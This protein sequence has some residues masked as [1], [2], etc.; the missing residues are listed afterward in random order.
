MRTKIALAVMLSAMMFLVFVAMP[1]TAPTAQSQGP[2]NKILARQLQIERGEIK[3][4]KHEMRI[5]S[6]TMYAVLEASGELAKRAAEAKAQG[7]DDKRPKNL[8]SSG[9]QGCQN[10]FKGPDGLLNI[11]VNQDCSLRRQAEEVIAINPTNPRNLIAGQNDSRIGFNHCGYDWSFDGGRTWGDQVPPFWQFILADGHTADACSDPT[12]T[13][14]A[15]GNAYVGGILFDINSAA[16]AFVV[17]KSNAGIGGA[18]YHSPDA[19]LSF[20]TYRDTPVG[21][22]ANDNNPN[23]FHDKEYIVADANASS[24]KKNNVY[25]TWTRF[26]ATNSPIYFS[27]STN[28]GATWSPGVEISG[29]NTTACTVGSGTTGQPNQCDQDQGSHPIVGPDGTIYVAFGNANTPLVGVNQVLFVKCPAAAN[30]ALAA[31]WSAPVKVGDLID[32]HPTGPSAA[33]CPAGRQ[34]LPPNGYRVPEFTSISTSVDKNS[35]LFVSWSDFRNGGGT[36]T[37]SASTATPPCDNDVFYS[38]S[39]NGGTTWSAPF[40]ITPK[41]KFNASA[42]WQPWS[43]I[44]PDGR[45]LY[46]A[47]YDRSYG[48]CETTGCN[49][50]TLARI[51]NPASPNPSVKYKRLT[52]GSMPNLTPA[53]NPIEAGFLGDYMWVATDAKGKPYVVWADTRGLN[54]TVEE[55]IYFAQFEWDDD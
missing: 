13:F 47:Y 42:Q 44:T 17:V 21:V 6:G 41:S 43:A 27:Q 33:G 18:F 29:K 45:T 19:S 34:C 4:S 24:P 22:V 30:C 5:S 28:G 49:D 32:N 36:C 2:A 25:A 23:V 31:S 52:T 40:N 14:D 53:N 10:V 20:Q 38:Y 55:D 8:S 1:D 50:I 11:R 7:H 54:D 9:T 35:K 39:T 16:S 51:K 46:A 12:A 26:T 15:N 37:G 3:T 48:N